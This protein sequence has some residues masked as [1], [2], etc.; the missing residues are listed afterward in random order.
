[1]KSEQRQNA[2]QNGLVNNIAD[3]ASKLKAVNDKKVRRKII[4][5]EF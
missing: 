1:M 2:I 5:K 3:S 4:E